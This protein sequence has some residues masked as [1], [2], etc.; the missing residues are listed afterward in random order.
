M[1]PVADT[2]ETHVVG[3]IPARVYSRWH[4]SGALLQLKLGAEAH[5]SGSAREWYWLSRIWRVVI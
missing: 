5:S 1:R 2:K 4:C 3:P